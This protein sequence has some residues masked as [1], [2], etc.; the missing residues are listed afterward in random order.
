[1]NTW[2][3]AARIVPTEDDELYEFIVR[4]LTIGDNMIQTVIIEQLAFGVCYNA[5]FTS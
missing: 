1:M 3:L 4:F 5:V 2:E